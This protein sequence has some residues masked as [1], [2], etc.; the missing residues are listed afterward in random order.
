MSRYIAVIEYDETESVFMA[1]F[2]DAPGCNA[3]GRTED[4]VIANAID[5]LSE[6]ALDERSEGR[7]LPSPRSYL[8][9][10]KSRKYDLGRGGMIAT[11]P[12]VL[13]TGK[14]TRANISMDAGLL[15]SIDEEATRQ[16]ITRSAFIAAAALERIRSKTA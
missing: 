10:L 8:E 7:A 14:I 3:S 2:P 12:L 16:G 6:W 4:E 11:I 9:L 5:A 13:E 1:S 15:A